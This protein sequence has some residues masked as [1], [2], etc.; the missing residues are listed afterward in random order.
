MMSENYSGI[1]AESGT[2]LALIGRIE[3]HPRRN[4]E[5]SP[6]IGQTFTQ[7]ILYISMQQVG[8]MH[9]SREYHASVLYEWFR[10]YYG[11]VNRTGM[12]M[13]LTISITS[14]CRSPL[15]ARCA[16]CPRRSIE[17]KSL[18]V[19]KIV[20]FLSRQRCDAMRARLRASGGRKGRSITIYMC[21]LTM[22]GIFHEK[23]CCGGVF[24]FDQPKEN[25]ISVGMRI[26][27]QSY[28]E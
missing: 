17:F 26:F 5:K 7:V 8:R 24:N 23:A 20:A 15:R 19:V 21:V 4:G 18:I 16:W 9:R 12:L 10:I 6:V 22:A 11:C 27:M 3:G 1:S 25:I 2:N 28:D 13:Q 14:P